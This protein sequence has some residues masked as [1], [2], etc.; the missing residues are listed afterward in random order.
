MFI[1]FQ[2]GKQSFFDIII[3]NQSR[4]E[5]KILNLEIFL[6]SSQWQ[7]FLKFRNMPEKLKQILIM[8]RISM[9]NYK[10]YLLQVLPSQIQKNPALKTKNEKNMTGDENRKKNL[11]KLLKFSHLI[12]FLRIQ[13]QIT[14]IMKTKWKNPKFKN[15]QEIS[16][17]K[18]PIKSKKVLAT[19][20]K[21]LATCQK[22][23][24]IIKLMKTKNLCPS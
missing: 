6:F 14:L 24:K 10:T 21:V 5:M 23:K 3:H 22:A 7:I 8:M 1:I 9:M 13:I 4:K 18:N 12:L 16:K 20:Q 17:K 2:T 19:C 11:L 15:E